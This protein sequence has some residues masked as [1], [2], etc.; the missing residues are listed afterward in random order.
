MKNY[1]FLEPVLPR[2]LENPQRWRKIV[3]LMRL[4]FVSL[5][6]FIFSLQVLLARTADAQNFSTATVAFNLNKGSLIKVFEQIE[7]QTS[8]RF[9]YL[10]PQIRKYVNLSIPQGKNKLQD[11]LGDL[12]VQTRLDYIVKGNTIVVLEQ[13][14]KLGAKYLKEPIRGTVKNASGNPL[15]GASVSIKGTTTGTYTNALGEYFIDVPLNATL[16]FS[17]VGYTSQEINIT[18]DRPLNVVL[19][20]TTVAAAD[21]VVI[22][23]FA[24]QKKSSL[25]SSVSTV[26]GEDLSFGGRNLTNNLQGQLPGIISF[27]RSG[28]PGY[29]NATFWIRGISTYNGVQNPL[30]LVDGVPRSF[31]D[32]DPNEIST[33]SVLKDAAAT[34]V[35]G[36]EGA[37]GVIL[38]TTKRGRVQKT[39]ITYR[40]EYSYL[41]PLRMPEF[42]GAAE[43][44]STFNEAL[45]NEGQPARFD[46]VLIEKYRSGIDRDLYPDVNWLD[47][48]MRN[49][50]NNTRHNLSFRG[51]TNKARYFVSGA[52]YKESG[53]FKDNAL[54]QY[55]SN[56]DLKRYNLRSNI[57]LDVTS[58]TLLRVDI[59]GQYLETNYPGTGT[60]KIFDLASSTPSYLFPA[61][62]SDGRLADHN[63]PSDNRSN[64]YNR[65]NHSGY[66]NEFRTN[67]QSRVD[68][69]QKLNVLTQGLSAKVSASY[70]FYGT[71]IVPTGK[72]INTYYATGRDIN[73]DL[74]YTQIKTGTGDITSGTQSQTVTKNIYLE[75][76]LNYNRVFNQKHDVTA[77]A[78][79]YKKESQLNNDRLPFRK[80]AYVGRLAYSYDRRYSIEANVGITGSETFAK[81]YRYGTFPAVGAAWIVSNEH[82]YPDGLKDVLSTLKFRASYGLTGNDQ[83]LVSGSAVRF[84][85]RGGFVSGTGATFGYNAGQGTNA[86][87][88]LVEDR[89]SSPQ[90]SWET[91]TKRNFAIDLGLF[92]DKLNITAEYWSNSRKDILIQRRT[93]SGAAGF[94]QQP[95]QNFGKVD[96]KGFDGN[97]IFRQPIGASSVVS[98][99]GNYTFARNKIVEYDEI[100]PLY[101]WMAFT[102]NR[103]NMPN[104]FIADRLFR[105][106][107][108]DIVTDGG[109]NKTYTLK[110]GIPNQNSLN[111]NVRPGDIKYKDLNDDGVIDQFDQTRYSG[112]PTTPE[113][114]YGF[115]AGYEYKGLSLNLFFTGIGNTSAIIGA[116]NPYAVFPFLRG[117]DESNMRTMARDRWQE[118]NGDDQNVLLPR[119]RTGAFINNS[120]GSTWWQRDASFLRLKTAELG[121]NLPKRFMDRLGMSKGRVYLLGYNLLTWDKIKFWDPEQ[122]S[123]NAGITYPQSRSFTLG[124]EIT[125]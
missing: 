51:G 92:R 36:A 52:F 18:D 82:F 16:V 57:D 42:V 123:D 68:L 47:L 88:G 48:L 95:F 11:F 87:G 22:V 41:T 110:A 45:R 8:F 64:P 109:G 15:E 96:N 6:F 30:V 125:F 29:D 67:I 46:D 28:E 107:D 58:T 54:A 101:P 10:E 37:N 108:F 83:Y 116:S 84:L 124:A 113:V 56:I 104:I 76:S 25:V 33:F 121:Y 7:K 91:E 120:T 77:M 43:Y 23:G 75:A 114:T 112:N 31:T 122:G 39:E 89:F 35:F 85:Y 26:S 44:L 90:L 4:S 80:M 115:G 62:Y 2:V 27:Q 79:A 17:F 9:A 81:G 14:D 102:G 78:L 50:T 93:V 65:L 100:P 66:T 103:L 49:H 21:S 53:L 94:R 60:A 55:S 118:G 61:I 34:S 20:A 119:I 86:V 59:S 32:I 73:G 99:R 40:G 13:K 19:A 111:V 72:S 5:T 63:N 38:V 106:S 3:Y 71:Y 98:F 24:K 69:E 105:D 117:V 97:I 1:A 70:D 74:I 12:F